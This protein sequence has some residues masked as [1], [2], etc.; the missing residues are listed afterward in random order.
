MPRY[1]SKL[2]LI[3][4]ANSLLSTPGISKSAA[5]A[6]SCAVCW[7]LTELPISMQ[8]SAQRKPELIING[9]LN[10]ERIG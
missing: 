9:L 2:S 7:L 3:Q 6:S 5:A 8:S 4:R 1:T 10:C